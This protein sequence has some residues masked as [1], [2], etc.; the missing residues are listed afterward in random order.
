MA[1]LCVQHQ[2]YC[3][4]YNIAYPYISTRACWVSW[5]PTNNNLPWIITL[6]DL[7]CDGPFSVTINNHTQNNDILSESSLYYWCSWYVVIQRAN[8][9]SKLL[10]FI[11]SHMLYIAHDTK[12][13][14]CM[15]LQEYACQEDKSPSTGYIQI[16]GLKL[17]TSVSADDLASKKFHK[18]W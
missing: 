18:E 1:G 10:S 7:I 11:I 13:D 17:S 4:H 15:F 12:N 8:T 16:W 6:I 3:V 14:I 2:Y 5:L 9:N